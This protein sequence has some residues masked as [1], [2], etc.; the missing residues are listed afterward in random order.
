M[1]L[2]SICLGRMESAP[3]F[4]QWLSCSA[5]CGCTVRFWIGRLCYSYCRWILCV[6]LW[7]LMLPSAVC[8]LSSQCSFLLSLNAWVPWPKASSDRSAATASQPAGLTFPALRSRL[9]T[10]LKW[11]VG[12]PAVRVPVASSPWSMSL[13]ILPSSMRLAWPSHRSRL[14]LS[15]ANA[16]GTPAR[17]R[18]SLFGTRSSQVM[19]IGSLSSNVFEGRSSTGS[20]RFSFSYILTPPN[21]YYKCLYSCRDDLPKKLQ[22]CHCQ[23]TCVAQKRRCLNSLISFW[24]SAGGRCWVCALGWSWGS[25]SRCRNVLST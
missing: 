15:K 18:T 25:R 1:L 10:S 19:P 20:E 6:A 13:R 23:L 5:C 2:A 21:L 22:N 3:R 11:R 8:A 14:W 9:Q 17:A 16:L 4:S 12:L 24:G 7:V